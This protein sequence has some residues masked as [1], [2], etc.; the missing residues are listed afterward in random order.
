MA[1]EGRPHTRCCRRSELSQFRSAGIHLELPASDVVLELPDTPAETQKGGQE[2]KYRADYSPMITA[3][4][5][6]RLLTKVGAVEVPN[7]SANA[8]EQVATTPAI[9]PATPASLNFNFEIIFAWINFNNGDLVP[10]PK[11]N[12]PLNRPGVRTPNAPSKESTKTWES[13]RTNS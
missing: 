13:S 7:V 9:T 8:Y 12:D 4:S 1:C 10:V 11:H 6:T 5:P 3:T 2:T